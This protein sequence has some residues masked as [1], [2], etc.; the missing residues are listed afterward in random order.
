[1]EKQLKKNIKEGMISSSP[2]IIGYLPVAIAFGL[3]SKN[4]GVS[5]GDT[6]LFSIIVYA[7]ASQFMA[8]DKGFFDLIY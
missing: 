4:T 1:M 8:L 2:V 6:G 3:L 5:L 7:G